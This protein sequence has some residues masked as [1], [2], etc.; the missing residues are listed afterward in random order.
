MMDHT[1]KKSNDRISSLDQFVFLIQGE[2]E[3]ETV[4][5]KSF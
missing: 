4:K 5:L 2:Q 3:E 1:I